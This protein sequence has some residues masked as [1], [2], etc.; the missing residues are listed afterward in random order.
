MLKVIV[1]TNV[2][3]SSLIQRNYP[4]LVVD[5]LLMETQIELCISDEVIREYVDVLNRVKFF[6]YPEYEI[7]SKMLI[8]SIKRIGFFYSPVGRV[9]II[10]DE[11]DN[12]FL[13]LA[14]TCNAD[15]L[16]TGNV[17]HFAM[18]EYKKTKIVTPKEFWEL[19]N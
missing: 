6:K 13:E 2:L 1:D 5:Y 7:R 4:F 10:H 15:Y 19:M 3:V 9:H 11:S 18:P 8:A 14:E 17:R 12:R 16:I